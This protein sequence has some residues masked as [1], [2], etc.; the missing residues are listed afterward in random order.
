MI[1]LNKETEVLISITSNPSNFGTTLYNNA[2]QLLELNYIYKAF[3]ISDL[4]GAVA[5]MRALGI[6]GCS[7]SMPFKI[8]I[9]KYLDNKHHSCSSTEAANTV[10]NKGGFLT[11]YNTDLLA[12]VAIIKQLNLNKNQTV[13]IAGLGGVAR[14]MILALKTAGIASIYAKVR[15]REQIFDD[16]QLENV[17]LINWD[18]DQ[19]ADVLINATPLG[20]GEL[21]GASPFSEKQ[22]SNAQIVIDYVV[23]D[24][25]TALL[26]LGTTHN[27]R[28]VPGLIF[29][30]EQFVHQFQFYTEQSPPVGRLRELLRQYYPTS[31]SYLKDFNFD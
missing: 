20:M 3:K 28:I 22:V 6:R 30:F 27:K 31:G 19:N 10:V 7:V 8:R 11:G 24:E 2:F 29:S 13:L 26:R 5:G 25:L 14:A 1:N 17:R 15:N 9:L 18:N 23:A 4:D 16:N 12:A 21:G